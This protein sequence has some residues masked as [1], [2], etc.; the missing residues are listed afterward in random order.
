MCTQELPHDWMECLTQALKEKA[1]YHVVPSR[2]SQC[3]VIIMTEKM[4]YMLK[5]YGSV[6]LM[7]G[8]YKTSTWGLPV[9]ILTVVNAQN[10]AYPACFAI[11]SSETNDS[12]M[13]LLLHV[14][15]LVPEWVPETFMVDKSDA[16]M[17]AIKMIFPL[18]AILLC[19][20]HVKQAWMRWIRKSDNGVGEEGNRQ[21]LYN[22]LEAIC[23]ASTFEAME[24]GILKLTD[25]RFFKN[26]KVQ[27]LWNTEWGNCLELWV[28]AHRAR[29]FNRGIDTNNPA[30]SLNRYYLI[31]SF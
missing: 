7:D 8:T 5:T 20:F 21:E 1:S 17:Y 30:E 28:G 19:Y 25:S 6:T 26:A 18:A 10:T 24:G 14:K 3:L 29:V 4:K 13:E 27:N 15:Q 2:S 23:H 12:I 16:E 22:L 9:V 11:V 31:Q